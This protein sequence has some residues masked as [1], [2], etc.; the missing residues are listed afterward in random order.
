ARTAGAIR[1]CVEPIAP[2]RKFFR[3]A[4]D[5]L[6]LGDVDL[7]KRNTDAG[8]ALGAS[9]LL[10]FAIEFLCC[11]LAGL[12]VARTEKYAETLARQLP[13]NFETNPFVAPVDVRDPFFSCL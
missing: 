10:C 13:D 9:F 12:L 7:H 11:L 1:Q 4:P 6:G 8:T 3:R 2:S 5:A